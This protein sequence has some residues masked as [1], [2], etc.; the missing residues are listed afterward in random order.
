MNT[1][2]LSLASA[3]LS[4]TPQASAPDPASTYTL[5]VAI[6]NHAH[7][8]PTVL[9]GAQE[10]ASYIFAKSGIDIRWMPCGREDESVEERSACGQSE[11]PD[12]L[13]MHIVNSCPHLPGGVFGISYLSPEGIGTQADVFY[14]RVAAFRRSPA[15]LSTLLGYATAHELGHL[16]LG[17]N[18]HSLTGLMCADWRTKELT[19][20]AQGGLGFGDEQAQRMKDKLATP[21]FRKGAS[22][23]QVAAG[24]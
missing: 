15:E 11:F 3:L 23:S 1:I 8:P 4:A 18:S 19:R 21:A 14:A 12:H 7:V 24:R 22:P 6:F 2:L 10:T 5:T 17:S 16:L 9:A 13:D 20:M